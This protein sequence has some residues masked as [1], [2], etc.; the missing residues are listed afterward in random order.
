MHQCKRT[1]YWV[2]EVLVSFC[3]MVHHAICGFHELKCCLCGS[4]FD[5]YVKVPELVE[6]RCCKA[7]FDVYTIN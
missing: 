4:L 1:C 6:P 7:F 5:F 3:M 2:L